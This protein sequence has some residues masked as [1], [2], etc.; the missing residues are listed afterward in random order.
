MMRALC[1]IALLLPVMASAQV[2]APQVCAPSPRIPTVAYPGVKAIPTS[3]DLTRYNGKAVSAQGQRLLIQLR[4]RDTRCVP[5]QGAIV[6][7]WQATP[8]GSIRVIGGSE[9]A[10][11]NAVFSGAGR[12]YSDNNGG[13]QFITLF[14]AALKNQA[15]RI[16]IRVKAANMKPYETIL[17]FENDVRN[18]SDAAYKRLSADARRRVELKMEPWAGDPNAGF[19]GATEIILPGKIRYRSY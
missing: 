18:G 19:I 16:H 14:P 13:V 9:R 5:I 8:Y 3:N 1:F 6:E 2:V 11:P 15:P 10:N 12:S 4:L 17:Y 7:L